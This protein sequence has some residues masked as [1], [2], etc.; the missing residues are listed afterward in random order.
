MVFWHP[1]QDV[2]PPHAH[3]GNNLQVPEDCILID[4]PHF[5]TLVSTSLS[6]PQGYYKRT[7]DYQPIREW[8][9][10]GCFT[11]PM[12]HSTF[13]LDLRR[14]SSR[15][16]AFNPPHPNYSW[17]FDDIMVFAFSARESGVCVCV[18]T[19]T[20]LEVRFTHHYPQ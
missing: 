13:L 2:I 10:L 15:A 17:A 8:R 16:L 19:V 7:P 18:F 9:R 14:S 11:V 3:R 6:L 12:I 20:P 5:Y 1:I 4:S